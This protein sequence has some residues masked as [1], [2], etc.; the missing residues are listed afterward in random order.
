MKIKTQAKKLQEAALRVA[1]VAEK[2]PQLPVLSC[3]LLIAGDSGVKLRATNLDIGV[4]YSLPA[5]VSRDGVCAVP[6]S[7]F[8][9]FLGTIAKDGE[10]QLSHE[11]DIL[12]VT[13]FGATTRFKTLPYED[14]PSIPT[15]EGSLGSA[16]IDTQ[17]FLSLL[18]SVS[19]AVSTSTVRPEL[20][21]IFL[22]SDGG[23]VTAAATDSFRLAERRVALPIPEIDSV[24]VP[25]KSI[26]TLVSL[27]GDSRTLMV[28]FDE[29]Q[30]GIRDERM[31]AVSRTTAGSFP[32][33]KQILPKVFAST[34]TLPTEELSRA[35]RRI[36]V[37][38]DAF[39][40]VKMVV[41]K[42]SFSVSSANAD[43]GEI[44]EQM[45]TTAEGDDMTLSFNYR[46]IAEVLGHL[47]GDTVR[48]SFAGQGKPLLIE[49]AGDASFSYIVMP[50]NR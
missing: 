49:A 5:T 38:S 43:V 40:K 11:G 50:M 34:V 7:T 29:H 39:S 3:I 35:L 21:S 37:F 13:A 9:G 4:E 25:G 16:D 2:N 8:A 27:F 14:F 36:A 20:A 10:L 31:N 32:D 17:G 44:E 47:T 45:N 24:L 48:L 12:S 6:A 23:T 15:V 22:S 41:E 18:K 46:Y 28:S 33:Y 42:K 19:F 26:G 1:R 30:F